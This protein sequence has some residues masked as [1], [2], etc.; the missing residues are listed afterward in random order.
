MSYLYDYRYYIDG[1]KIAIL[2]R[3][4]DSTYDPFIKVRDDI[5][6]TPANSDANGIMIEYNARPTRV[7]LE[8]DTIDLD[9]D[10]AKALVHYIKA[11][12]AS[13]KS[14]YKTESIEMNKFYVSVVERRRALLGV[15]TP[16]IQT[17]SVTSLK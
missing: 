1:R 6:L 3:S 16:V 7:T 12:V 2:Q 14:D 9:Q 10:L 8:T 17:H 4:I 11:R 15:S 13:D 5:Y